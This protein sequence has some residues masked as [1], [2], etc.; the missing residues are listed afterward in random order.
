M[1][2]PQ[3][4]T[5]PT[6]PPVPSLEYAFDVAVEVQSPHDHGVTRAGHRRVIPIVGGR[7]TG[8]V[9]AEILPGGADW[10]V[11]RRD[12]TIEID[13]QYTART[14]HGELLVLRTRGVRSGPPEVLARMSR[15]EP[16]V[17]SEYYFRTDLTVETSAER[18]AH[19]ERACFVAACMRD[20][21]GVRY[22]VYRVT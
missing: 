2:S 16:V 11:I 10:Q 21:T 12:G 5:P 19:L 8:G 18:L 9:E 22:R 13:A 17:P 6:A 20:A 4:N 15:G 1:K 7:L 14:E 3:Q